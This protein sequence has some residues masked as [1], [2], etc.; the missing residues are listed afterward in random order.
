MGDVSNVQLHG[1]PGRLFWCIL[2][3]S[4]L[5]IHAPSS[6]IGAGIRAL[7]PPSRRKA[8]TI[9]GSNEE[10]SNKRTEIQPMFKMF[11]I[12]V[13]SY[14]HLTVP[15]LLTTSTGDDGDA[16]FSRTRDL[17]LIQSVPPMDLLNMKAPPHILTLTE[18]PLDSLETE[19][20]ATSQSNPSQV[21]RV[22]SRFSYCVLF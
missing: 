1:F 4:S 14:H 10:L 6:I 21:V 16:Q 22:Q 13:T 2:A 11:M 20:T 7:K 15:L 12:L 19:Q 17:D 9:Y 18:Q 5:E 3:H 8:R